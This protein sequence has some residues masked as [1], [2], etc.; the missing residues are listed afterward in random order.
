[1]MVT[2]TRKKQVNWNSVY[3]SLRKVYIEFGKYRCLSVLDNH[4][5]NK[6]SILK[7]LGVTSES[8]VCRIQNNLTGSKI[9]K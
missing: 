2:S 9:K 6:E 8:D 4:S 7:R 5:E 3:A 1:M